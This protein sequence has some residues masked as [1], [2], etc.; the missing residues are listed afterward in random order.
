MALIPSQTP[1]I[2]S[3]PQ[4][5]PQPNQQTPLDVINVL[6]QAPPIKDAFINRTAFN[7]DTYSDDFKDLIGYMEGARV[8]VVYYTRTV[9]AEDR[10]TDAMDVST[11]RNAIHQTYTCISNF[12]ITLA[13]Q[14]Q[15]TYDNQSTEATISGEAFIYPGLNPN[16]GDIFL[17][18]LTDGKIARFVVGSVSPLSMRQLRTYK[19][20]FTARDFATSDNIQQLNDQSIEFATFDK[21]TYMTGQSTLLL[22]DTYTQL[23]TLRQMRSVIAKYYYSVFF[24][25]SASAILS[26]ENLYDPYLTKFLSSKISFKDVT[27]RSIQLPIND[28]IFQNTIW[29]RMLEKYNATCDGLYAAYRVDVGLKRYN[30]VYITGLLNLPTLSIDDQSWIN[31]DG[32]INNSTKDTPWNCDA[33]YI[34]PGQ[35]TYVFSLNFYT[36]NTVAMTPLEAL[37]YNTIKT[38]QIAD[39][40]GLINNYINVYRSIPIDAQFYQIPLILFLIDVGIDTIQRSDE[41]AQEYAPQPIC[42]MIDMCATRTS[43]TICQDKDIVEILHYVD[44]YIAEAKFSAEH[45]EDVRLY[46]KKVLFFRQKLYPLFNRILNRH[47]EWREAYTGKSTMAALMTELAAKIGWNLTSTEALEQEQKNFVVGNGA[48]IMRESMTPEERLAALRKVE[49]VIYDV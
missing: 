48:P 4:P 6:S 27:A 1:H 13:D 10:R 45:R 5:S 17:Y 25:T 36:Q 28:F 26:R 43:F 3:N 8:T 16:V 11:A 24:D 32:T 20:T 21:A 12:E 38:R 47:P 37:V 31:P 30:D 19:I 39:V 9:T 22:S 33:T 23:V 40:D 2:G 42:N 29:G 18:T 44:A 15:F 49:Q 14:L 46:L 7:P 41:N 34:P 35:P